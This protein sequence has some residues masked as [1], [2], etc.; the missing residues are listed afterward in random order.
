MSDAGRAPNTTDFNPNFAP[1]LQAFRD[2]LTKAGIQTTIASGYRSP[3]YQ[4]QMYQNH[5]AKKAG[6]PL[7]YPN[8]EAPKVV[9]PAWSSFHNYGLAADVTPT[10]PADYKRMWDMAPQF[11]LTALRE[12]DMDHFQMSGSLGANIAQYKLAGW[13]PDSSPAPASGAIAFNGPGGGT[14]IDSANAPV[15][16]ALAKPAG[17]DYYHTQMMH[18]SGGNN[19][20][21]SVG[22]WNAAG[23]YYQFTPSTYAGI[24]SAH[25]DLNL[26]E[27][28]QDA[29][30]DQQT[31]AMKALTSQNVDALQKGGVPIT[32]QN[33]A[34]AHFLGPGGAVKFYNAMTQNPGASAADLFPKEAASNPTVFNSKDGPRTL[35][36]VFALQTVGHGAGNT[37]GFGP[38]AAPSTAAP[39]VAAGAP[40][41]GTAPAAAPAD[42][43]WA[44]QAWSK[45]TGSPTDA[46]GNPTGGTSPLQQLSQA[47]VAR[48]GAEG[49]TEKQEAPA[50]SPLDSPAPGARNVSPGLAN[51]A[52]VYGQTLN[53]FSQPLTWTSKAAG[54]PGMPPA[55][56]QQARA[57]T[58]P[59]LSLTSLPVDPNGLGYGVDPN[60]GYGYG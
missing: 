2:A 27:N 3:E 30:Q 6:N 54:P 60:L 45:L 16:G 47:S 58:T 53:S 41:A 15:A 39:A 43:S 37:T 25:P 33:V 55:G 56:L 22:G 19:I 34:M 51:V 52:Q 42:Q 32:D 46:Q 9:A 21:N 26:P 36:Q 57:P 49:Q 8:V 14:T 29:N 48:L 11:G 18:E 50:K 31:A 35:Q 7:P 38:D 40:A 4:D 1:R 10:N 20:P 17:P 23:G 44:S 28:I 12:K 59:G 13:R 24:R 5:L